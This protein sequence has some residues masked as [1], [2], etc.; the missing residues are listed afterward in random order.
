MQLAEEIGVKYHDAY[1]DSKLIINQEHEE[2]EVRHEYLVTYHNVIIDM[3]EKFKNFYIDH[4]SRQQN[5]YADA[6]ASLT[7]SLALPAGA[8]EIVL[9]YSRDL[10]YCKFALQDSKALRGDLQVKEVHET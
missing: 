9:I 4:V 2:Y 8:I 1:G 10:Y 7:A 5:A 3:A 6:L